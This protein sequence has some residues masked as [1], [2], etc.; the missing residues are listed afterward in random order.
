MGDLITKY[1]KEEYVAQVLNRVTSRNDYKVD[2]GFPLRL[3]TYTT[4][5]LSNGDLRKIYFE[6]Y[7]GISKTQQRYC[8]L[9]FKIILSGRYESVNLY[10]LVA[11]GQ[12][13]KLDTS[14]IIM[15]RS[16]DILEVLTNNYQRVN[17]SDYGRYNYPA[18]LVLLYEIV[19]NIANKLGKLNS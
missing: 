18:D 1:T 3:S 14:N 12:E 19:G 15:T 13:S 11:K 4:L 8:K 5:K 9:T 6:S 16:D 2:L 10:L 17:R 7:L